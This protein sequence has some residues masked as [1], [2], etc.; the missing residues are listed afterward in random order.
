MALKRLNFQG[1]VAEKYKLDLHKMRQNR[2]HTSIF[3]LW[4]NIDQFWIVMDPCQQRDAL[5]FGQLLNIQTLSK[6]LSAS[7]LLLRK[8]IL[9]KPQASRVF[10]LFP[11]ILMYL[12]S[13]PAPS[14]VP[15]R[16]CAPHHS[17]ALLPTHTELNIFSLI[18]T[19]LLDFS[20]FCD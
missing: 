20:S 8:N 19:F 14:A 18:V 10:S 6:T 3:S 5:N 17:P 13:S 1:A 7:L 9:E 15:H 2:F 11:Y 16:P 12:C 4:T